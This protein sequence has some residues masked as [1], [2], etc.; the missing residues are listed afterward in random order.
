MSRSAPWP[1]EPRA[2]LLGGPGH[3]RT[4]AWPGDQTRVAWPYTDDGGV[5][6]SQAFYAPE[7]VGRVCRYPTGVVIRYFRVWG[8][9]GLEPFELATRATTEWAELVDGR[10]PILIDDR[11]P[12]WVDYG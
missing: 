7:V 2:L 3:G 1:G 6:F 10:R 12:R 5:S 8:W 11:R 9:T 4:V